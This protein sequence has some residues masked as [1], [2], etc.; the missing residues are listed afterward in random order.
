MEIRGKGSVNCMKREEGMRFKGTII[1]LGID[2]DLL[3]ILSFG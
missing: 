3:S 2:T 1:R